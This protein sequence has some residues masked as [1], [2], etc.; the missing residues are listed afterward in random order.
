MRNS[1]PGSSGRRLGGINATA[2]VLRYEYVCSPN[3]KNCQ[4]P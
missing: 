4:I 1:G 3:E 2:R